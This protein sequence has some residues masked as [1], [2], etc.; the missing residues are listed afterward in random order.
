MQERACRV[1]P[2]EFEPLIGAGVVARQAEVVEH[3]SDVEQFRIRHEA[4][5]PALQAAPQVHPPG[6]VEHKVVGGLP[7]QFGGFA[8]QRGVWNDDAC[9]LRVH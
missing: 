8:Y 2:V 3:R 1:R 5:S 7:D 9:D 6:M 4:P